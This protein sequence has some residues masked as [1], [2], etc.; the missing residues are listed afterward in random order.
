MPCL[1]MSSNKHSASTSA[2]EREQAKA[3]AME[4][5]ERLIKAGRTLATA[6][7]CTSGRIAALLTTISGAS[8]Y[9]QGG[10]VA[11]QDRIKTQYLGVDADVIEEHD[12][13]SQPVV[14]QMV[15]GAC[16]MFKTD[17]AL[18][19]TGYAGEGNERIPSGTIWL[20]WGS[21]DK[22]HSTCLTTNIDRET[23][24][25]NAVHEVLKRFLEFLKKEA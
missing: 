2:T 19:S 6:E 20:A 24:T 17:Y 23:N 18:A 25:Q 7:S 5:Q 9:F 16:G 1:P 14:E 15:R 10:L 13:V 12:V 8:G 22:V 11:Y 4:I 21:R 3:T